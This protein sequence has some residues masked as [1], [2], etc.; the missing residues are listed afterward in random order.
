VTDAGHGAW[1]LSLFEHF[2]LDLLS[3]CRY[4]ILDCCNLRFLTFV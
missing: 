4:K 1:R 3:S 2:P